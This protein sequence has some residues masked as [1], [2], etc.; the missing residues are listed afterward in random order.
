MRPLR[1]ATVVLLPLL[2]IAG[3]IGFLSLDRLLKRTIETQSTNSLRLRTTLNRARLS[4]FGGKVNLNGLRIASPP[5][6]PAPYLLEL[7]DVDVA[8]RYGQLRNDPIHVQSLA[9]RQPRLVIEQYNGALNFR[10]AKDRSPPGTGS[11]SEK[12]LKLVID[13][14]KMQD[15]QVVI[16]PGLPGVRQ[17]II[18]PV[19]AIALKNIGSGR[20][21]QNGAE[22]NH[23]AGVVI[24]VLAA[25]AAQS[26]SLPPEL[27]AVLQLNVGR[28]AGKLG[29][30][31]QK[32][33]AAAV[34]GELGAGL[35]HVAADPE[36]LVKDPGKVLQDQAGGT[37]G[38]KSTSPAAGRPASTP[39]R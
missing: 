12:P 24:A 9:L 36:G 20:G 19:P 1:R 21:A 37:L 7:G 8:V 27:R 2:V 17:E 28:V 4:L 23:V 38:G 35:S 25:S 18:V 32:Q 6:F 14:L 31:A 34:P 10:A 39:K 33:I 13:E 29:A 11:A 26:S 16:H 15:A 5:G 3:L 22:I 30:E